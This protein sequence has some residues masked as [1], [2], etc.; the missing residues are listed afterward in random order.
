MIKNIKTMYIITKRYVICFRIFI[1]KR[2]YWVE[3]SSLLTV[4][5]ISVYT[6]MNINE[7]L[8]CLL[9]V[10]TIRINLFAMPKIFLDTSSDLKTT[11]F[12]YFLL[13]DASLSTKNDRSEKIVLRNRQRNW[14]VIIDASIGI[15]ND[16]ITCWLKRSLSKQ[17]KYT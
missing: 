4:Y 14:W 12:R 15:R 6:R 1:F 11:V 16:N 10:C 7:L 9:Q 8:H 5:I 17:R 13:Y 2:E 3:K